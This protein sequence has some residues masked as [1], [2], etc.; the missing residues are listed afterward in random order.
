MNWTKKVVKTMLLAVPLS[1]IMTFTACS[2]ND[3][4][5]AIPEE[6]TLLISMNPTK[7]T[8]SGSP[9]IL[10]SLLHISKL[11]DSGLDLSAN[12]YFFEDAQANIGV[13]AKVD[14]SDKLSDL[15]K[16]AHLG[17]TERRGCHFAALPSN[18]V[19]GFSDKAA[20]LMGPVLPAAQPEMITLMA[21]YLNAD[22]DD[23]VKNSP[24]YDKL[25]SIEGPMA[26]VSQAQA[27]P[28][29]LVAPFT[30][31]APKDCDPSDVIVAAS[32]EVKGSQ[33]LMKGQTYSLKKGVNDA[34]LKAQKVYRPIKGNY[35]GAMSKSDVMGM[36]LNV[37][38]QQFH[39]LIS[40][41]RGISAMLAGIN[42]AIDI[43]NIL[44]SV[45]GDLTILSPTLAKGSM[46]I[47]MAAKLSNAK[48]LGDVDYWKQSVP[49]GGFIGD[50]GKNCFYY[51]DNS[52]SYYFGVTP[53]LQYMSG[54]NPD[55]ARSS[56]K[57][58]AHPI[59]KQLQQQIVGQ[60][61]VM[62]INF[63]ALQG[64]KA[65]AVTALLKPMFGHVNTI[66]YT[67]K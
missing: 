66:V 31:G 51:R 64:S 46:S 42:A 47:M 19:I 40:H 55:Q 12:V 8:G 29:Q 20:L 54:S 7:L 4:L 22:E 62:I 41:N 3:Y 56:I 44:K 43:D 61:L 9:L 67:M 26:L 30:I 65:E 50:W 25:D 35:V 2:G 34:L 52:T 63:G 53:D 32:M 48:W 18:W 24:L 17:L 21:K 11:N 60:K 38:G 33:L 10:K 6:S 16:R 1:L 27:L 59:D 49:K 36:F 28:E 13:C 15:L 37:N 57:V 14:D 58:S 23:G 5:N 39:A 45:D